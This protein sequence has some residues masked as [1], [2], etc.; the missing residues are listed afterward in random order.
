MKIHKIPLKEM[1]V[2]LLTLPSGK[3]PNTHWPENWVGL[4]V[5]G[6]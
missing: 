5:D 1:A 3:D 2:G 6:E 4:D